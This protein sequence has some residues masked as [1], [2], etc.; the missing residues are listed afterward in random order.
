MLG[1]TTSYLLAIWLFAGKDEVS[2]WRTGKASH[3]AGEEVAKDEGRTE[4][5]HVISL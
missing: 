4:L 1:V 2:G 3:A 5:L